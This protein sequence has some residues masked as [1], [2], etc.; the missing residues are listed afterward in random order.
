MER[1]GSFCPI[2]KAA[3]ILTERWTLL[4]LRELLLGS[5]HFN[6]FRR[7]IPQMSATTLSKRLYTLEAAGIVERVGDNGCH[8]EYRPTAA[9]EDLRHVIELI[10][11]WGQR[12]VRS[13]LTRDELDPGMLMWFVSRH[14]P[15]EGPPDQRIV[16]QL[17]FTDVRRMNRWWLVL[18]NGHVDLCL[19]N[20][21]F[22]IDI[23]L[24]TDLLTLTEVFMG[25]RSFANA[26]SSGKLMMEGSTAL[27]R[28]ISRWFARSKF[29]DTKPAQADLPGARQYSG[30]EIE[31]LPRS[32]MVLADASTKRDSALGLRRRRSEKRVSGGLRRP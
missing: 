29:A 30:A 26:V 28:S 25:A 27:T 21:G 15:T 14:F 19:D 3:E 16:I 4:V 24:S 18:E 9:C 13:R 20:P 17:E 1:Y 23:F 10:G 12:W 6:E 7:G 5:R 32:G 8:W 2:A 11:H 22:P 31:C